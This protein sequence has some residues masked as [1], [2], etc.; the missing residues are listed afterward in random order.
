MNTDDE[1]IIIDDEDMAGADDDE[2]EG[3]DEAVAGDES[4][5]PNAIVITDEDRAELAEVA[6]AAA[7]AAPP[8]FPRK[9]AFRLDPLPGGGWEGTV[10]VPLLDGQVVRS[11]AKG[12]DKASALGRA[13]SLAKGIEDNPVLAALL[14]PQATMALKA[15]TALAKAAKVGKLGE[16]AKKFSGPAMKR[17]GKVLGL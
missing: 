14:P 1:S 15:T 2:D 9:L 8:V 12:A 10:F 5:E 7:A 6:G 13:A 4:D 11:R 16:V 3:D 17:L